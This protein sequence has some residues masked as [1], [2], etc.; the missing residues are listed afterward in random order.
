MDIFSVG[1]VFALGLVIGSF[2]N[3]VI[4]RLERG[5]CDPCIRLRCTLEACR[6]GLH[7]FFSV[8]RAGHTGRRSVGDVSIGISTAIVLVLLYCFLSPG[9]AA[10]YLL[11]FILMSFIFSALIVIFVYDY[12]HF[13][14]PDRVVFPA[15]GASFL[16]LASEL[17][18]AED[19]A[20]FVS[21]YLGAAILAGGFFLSLIWITRGKGMGGGDVKLGFLMGM[22]LGIS[23]TLLALF[24]AFFTGAIAGVA[25]MTTKRK[26]MKSEMPFGPFLILGFMV[27]FFYGSRI[28]EWYW[29]TLL[30]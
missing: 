1:I 27:S 18:R 5:E 8:P 16:L 17:P 24:L 11:R 25:L 10:G 13:I 9:P 12:R 23:Q 30:F 28:L 20:V 22:V 19:K 4:S 15:I 26:G 3:V 7:R 21:D 6:S 14:I 2:L 29:G